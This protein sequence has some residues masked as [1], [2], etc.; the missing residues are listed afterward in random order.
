MKSLYDYGS[1]VG[2]SGPYIGPAVDCITS[3]YFFRDRIYNKFELIM[4]IIILFWIR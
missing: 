1:L 3:H 2:L 4:V